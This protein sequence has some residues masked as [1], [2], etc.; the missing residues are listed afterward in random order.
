MAVLVHRIRIRT[1]TWR[2]G[3][4]LQQLQAVADQ[5][6]ERAQ[7]RR[8]IGQ[9]YGAGI[10][11]GKTRLR[12]ASHIV[13]PTA[14]VRGSSILV[15]IEIVTDSSFGRTVAAFIDAGLQISGCL[16]GVGS[17]PEDFRVNTIDIDLS[18]TNPEETI[19]DDIVD[20]LEVSDN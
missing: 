15:E 11:D 19:L 13:L 12:H 3:P 16:R 5:I 20:A 2:Q 18:S 8:M 14:R 1:Y 9:I 4:T 10:N 6:N 17:S 7:D